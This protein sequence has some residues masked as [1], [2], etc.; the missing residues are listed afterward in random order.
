[1]RR[2][3]V[4]RARDGLGGIVGALI[5]NALEPVPYEPAET[6]SLRADIS[7]EEV[8]QLRALWE[9]CRNGDGKQQF[10]HVVVPREIFEKVVK[11]WIL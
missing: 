11:I 1:M 9:F 7:P 2:L 5:Y 8:G 6:F 10:P 3:E 4:D